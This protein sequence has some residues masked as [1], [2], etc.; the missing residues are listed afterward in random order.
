MIRLIKEHEKCLFEEYVLQI[1]VMSAVSDKKLTA[2]V[3]NYLII[4]TLSIF[5]LS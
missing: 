3:T 2:V 4:C 5:N 1:R